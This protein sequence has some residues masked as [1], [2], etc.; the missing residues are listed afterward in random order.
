MM[1]CC[2]RWL[3]ETPAFRLAH[4]MRLYACLCRAPHSA[5]GTLLM[6]TA[7]LLRWPR[8]TCKHSYP[9]KPTI[10]TKQSCADPGKR[11]DTAD[12]AASASLRME[13]MNS[14]RCND[15]QSTRLRFVVP[16]RLKA[17]VLTASAVVSSIELVWKVLYSQPH[18]HQRAGLA[19][20]A[21]RRAHDQRMCLNFL[22]PSRYLRH[23]H[24]P[25]HPAKM[26]PAARTEEARQGHASL[27]HVMP[28][29]RVPLGSPCQQIKDHLIYARNREGL[30]RPRRENSRPYSRVAQPAAG[31]VCR[32]LNGWVRRLNTRNCGAFLC[33]GRHCLGRQGHLSGYHCDFAR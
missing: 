22:D 20:E 30:R 1:P 10:C 11:L 21:N 24:H 15:I 12:M 7:T 5:M 2:W 9:H 25:R 32:F 16:S 13:P 4:S 27:L 23:P 29:V 19:R 33:F 18:R 26:P 28:A 6:A 31:R 8:P 14:G 17:L 3:K